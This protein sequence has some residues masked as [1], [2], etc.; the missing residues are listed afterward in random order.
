LC[1]NIVNELII[2][3]RN[4]QKFAG[5]MDKNNYDIPAVK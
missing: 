1:Q 2:G 4:Y 5:A 3:I